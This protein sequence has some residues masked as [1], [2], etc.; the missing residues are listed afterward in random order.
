MNTNVSMAKRSTVVT[1]LKQLFRYLPEGT[2]NYYAHLIYT[3]VLLTVV[4]LCQQVINTCAS[5]NKT[6]NVWLFV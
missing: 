4:G 2:D 6:I 3:T 5:D 1:A